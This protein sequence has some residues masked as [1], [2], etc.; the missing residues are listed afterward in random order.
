MRKNPSL[1]W[2]VVTSA[3]LGNTNKEI[4]AFETEVILCI[5]RV[6]GSSSSNKHIQINDDIVEDN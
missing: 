6:Y 3:N 5:R 2:G 4:H 1:G